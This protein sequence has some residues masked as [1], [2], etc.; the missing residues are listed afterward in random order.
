MDWRRAMGSILAA[1]VLAAGVTSLG[2]CVG[3]VVGGGATAAT[4]AAQERGFRGAVDDTVIRA[5]I[6]DLWLAHDIDMY[7]KVSLSVIEGRVLLTGKVEQSRVRLDAVRL[8]WQA[9]G[10]REVINE[11]IVTSEGS[12]GAYA[13]DTWISTQLK[14]RILFDRSIFSINYSIET[15]AGVVYLMG[16]AQDQAELNRV[17]NHARNLNYVKKVVSYVRLKDDPRRGRT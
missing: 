13:R 17:T 8:A 2:G 7:R 9:D 15:V 6:N 10:V 5:R 16:I 4:A 3:A 14:T 11:I 1:A 12:I